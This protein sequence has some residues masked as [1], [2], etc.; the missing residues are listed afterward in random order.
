[1]KLLNL[2]PDLNSEFK[3]LELIRGLV[4]VTT[5]ATPLKP[6]ACNGN[7]LILASG[8]ILLSFT[9]GTDPRP[10]I[11]CSLDSEILSAGFISENVLLVSTDRSCRKVD[12]TTGKVQ[13]APGSLPAVVIRQSGSVPISCAIPS[14]KVDGTYSKT[15]DIISGTDLARI[16]SALKTV[17]AELTKDSEAVNL[18]LNPVFARYRLLDSTGNTLFVSPA[19]LLSLGGSETFQLAKA[20]RLPI[21]NGSTLATIYSCNCFSAEVHIPAVSCPEVYSL[22]VEVSD[23]VSPVT[24]SGSVF[25]GVTRQSDGTFA[26]NAYFPGAYNSLNSLDL[27]RKALSDS[28]FKVALTVRNPFDGKGRAVTVPASTASKSYVEESLPITGL[29]NADFS[30]D[31]ISRCGDIIL[32]SNPRFFRYGGLNPLS[33]AAET[34]PKVCSCSVMVTFADGSRVVSEFSNMSQTPVSLNPL[35]CHPSADAVAISFNFSAGSLSFNVTKPLTPAPDG[36]M[37][38]YLEPDLK[39]INLADFHSV[40]AAEH[41]PSGSGIFRDCKGEVMSLRLNQPGTPVGLRRVSDF[42][43]SFITPATGSSAAW[44]HLRARFVVFAPDGIYSATCSGSAAIS[45]IAGISNHAVSDPCAIAVTPQTLYFLSDT[46]TLASLK[47]NSVKILRRLTPGKIAWDTMNREI[48]FIP[49]VS[50]GR[51]PIYNPKTDL[52]YSRT[53][54]EPPVYMLNHVSG[55]FFSAESGNIYRFGKEEVTEGISIEYLE[56]VAVKGKPYYDL[57]LP[58]SS[59]KPLSLDITV[60]AEHGSGPANSRTIFR[61]HIEGPLNSPLRFPVPVPTSPRFNLPATI[62]HISIKQGSDALSISN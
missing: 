7:T 2:R 8:S 44:D 59:T 21:S 41:T 46:G 45:N 30:V 32:A 40:P 34:E 14:L 9:A 12:M 57:L 48:I 17:L 42:A 35:I 1:M 3:K 53:L 22:Q 39:R 56:T 13:T 26:F 4:P 10:Q 47:G 25:A 31:C 55:T 5:S 54:P 58:I 52:D 33:V 37:A 20:V 11:V 50:G 23:P 15:G 61:R 51:A 6:V 49:A 18:R 36:S 27:A 43:V 24:S 38:Y 16:S 19:V 28:R 62:L 29:L 60:R